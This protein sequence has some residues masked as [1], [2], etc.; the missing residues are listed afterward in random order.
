LTKTVPTIT[1]TVPLVLDDLLVG[2]MAHCS[3]RTYSLLQVHCHSS[4][5]SSSLD[6]AGKADE[7][8]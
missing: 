5:F 1:T 3:Q 4:Y 7:A 6:D 8:V 2:S